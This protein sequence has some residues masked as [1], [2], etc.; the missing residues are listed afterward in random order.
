M[1]SL[2]EE[3]LFGHFV[4]TLNNAFQ[5]ELGQE[6]EGYESGNECLNI[7]TP[8]SSALRVY[9]VSNMEELSFN[10][11]NFGQSPATPE[12]HEGHSLGGY[13][14]CSFTCC[15]LVLTSSDDESP[16]RPRRQCFQHSST[17]ARSPVHRKTYLSSPEH[18]NQCHHCM[19]TPNTEQFFIDFDNHGM[20]IQ[21]PPRKPPNS[22]I[23]QHSLICR[24]NSR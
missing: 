21:L 13:R 12:H 15:Q 2:P 10:P 17:N 9:H 7:P 5:T 4:T 23:G 11:T 19:P 22:I 20:K 16:R 8:L 14:H 18:H 6:D 3:T 1:C 24:S